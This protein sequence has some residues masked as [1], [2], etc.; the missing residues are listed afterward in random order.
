MKIASKETKKDFLDSN[1][2]FQQI[3]LMSFGQ[4]L[5][6]SKKMVKYCSSSRLITFTCKKIKPSLQ[7]LFLILPISLVT[8]T[9]SIVSFIFL[10]IY[11]SILHINVSLD[12]IE[13]KEKEH[14]QNL[15]IKNLIEFFKRLQVRKRIVGRGT[16]VSGIKKST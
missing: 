11:D 9:G 6:Y 8:I 3:T 15:T 1:Q 16:V 2:P 12:F 7:F 5:I 10:E 14:H 13:V 4:D